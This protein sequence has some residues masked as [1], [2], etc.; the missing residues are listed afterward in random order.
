[1][2]TYRTGGHAAVST[3]GSRR[4]AIPSLGSSPALDFSKQ[5]CVWREGNLGK[6]VWK[7]KEAAS[8][9]T[10]QQ[11]APR[12]FCW[13]HGGPVRSE[14]SSWSG[15]PGSRALYPA[16]A[17]FQVTREPR[18]RHGEAATSAKAESFLYRLRAGSEMAKPL[19]PP[20]SSGLACLSRL[21]TRNFFPQ[22]PFAGNHRQVTLAPGS[23]EHAHYRR[24]VRCGGGPSAEPGTLRQVPSQLALDVAPSRPR[25]LADRVSVRTQLGDGPSYH[26]WFKFPQFSG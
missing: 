8:L 10:A 20:A 24:L 5:A 2:C 21:A 9:Q 13:R 17:V 26:I 6:C 15:S 11:A 23:K 19:R 1:M 7:E 16:A 12:S 3:L 25:N 14:E 18:D 4:T 22:L